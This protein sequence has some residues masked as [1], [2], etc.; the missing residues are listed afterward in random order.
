[1]N[2]LLPTEI[3]NRTG[4]EVDWDEWLNYQPGLR[5]EVK[6]KPGVFDTIATYDPLMVPPIWLQ[7]DPK[8]YYPHELRVYRLGTGGDRF[9]P[10]KS[11][12]LY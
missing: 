6:A 3:S 1:M 4:S 2:G 12:N 11:I 8:P 5:V 7:H 10:E 9:A